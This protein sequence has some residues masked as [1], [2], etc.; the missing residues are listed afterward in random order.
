MIRRRYPLHSKFILPAAFVL[1][2]ATLAAVATAAEVSAARLDGTTTTGTLRQ[3]D[4]DQVMIATSAGD[5]QLATRQ[6]ISLRWQLAPKSSTS[7][8]KDEGVAELIDGS[9][10]PVKSIRIEQSKAALTLARPAAANDETLSLPVGKLAAIRFRLLEGA[11]GRQWEEIRH[12]NLANDVLAVLKRDG[13]SLDYVEG[14]LGEV[15]DDK[16]EFKLEGE[17]QRVDRAKIAGV[18]FYRPDRRTKEEPRASIQG[19]SGLRVSATH[20]ELKDLRLELTTGAGAKISWPLDDIS[21]ADFSAGKLVYLSD[22]EPASE[23]WIPLVGLPP[24]A[25][26]ALE[27]G[28]PRR[29]K[30]AY[31]GPLTLLMK[32]DESAAQAAPRSFNKGL[33]LRSRT[34]LVYRLPEGFKRFIAVAGIDPATATSGNVQLVI[35]GDNRVLL[36][37]EIAGDQPPQPIQLQIAGVKR[38]K[39]IVDYGQNLDTGDWLNMCDARIVK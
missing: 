16:I 8:A 37:S 32:D 15:S 9:I 30:S 12:Q 38:L 28:Q 14:V 4:D 7:D 33:A 17:I 10:L 18:I 6:L 36:E 20:V 11:L 13:K 34:E 19:R 31:G 29:D 1:A 39:I 22:I 5:Q 24:T 23:N 21:F 2:F 3:W 27:Y 35:S 26:V 25:T